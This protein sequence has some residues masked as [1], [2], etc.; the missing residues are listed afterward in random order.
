MGPTSEDSCCCRLSLPA[1]HLTNFLLP[2]HIQRTILL[3]PLPRA[4]QVAENLLAQA[5][6]PY[7]IVYSRDAVD[8]LTVEPPSGNATQQLVDQLGSASTAG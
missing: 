5:N 7:T 1:P 4:R 8:P 2:G 3:L 6:S